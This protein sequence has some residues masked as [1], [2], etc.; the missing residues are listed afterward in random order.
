MFNEKTEG[1]IQHEVKLRLNDEKFNT[2]DKRFDKVDSEMK[3]IRDNLSKVLAILRIGGTALALIAIPV[4]L[5][6]FGK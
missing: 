5:K 1:Y 3:N 2:I 6:Y 4:L